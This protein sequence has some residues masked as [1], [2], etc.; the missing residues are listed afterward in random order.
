MHYRTQYIKKFKTF[1]YLLLLQRYF[2]QVVNKHLTTSVSYH[3]IMELFKHHPDLV[4]I[5]VCRRKNSLCW[6]SV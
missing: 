5:D 1:N 6:I 2:F 4:S 3:A